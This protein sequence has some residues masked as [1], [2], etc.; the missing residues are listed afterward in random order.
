M[1]SS[2]SRAAASSSSP[3][4]TR[5]RSMPTPAPR[6][7]TD[8]TRSR[9][10]CR[11][12]TR[13]NP[14]G[15]SSQ[16][17]VRV[18]V[19]Y[20]AAAPHTGD[21]GALDLELKGPGG[22]VLKVTPGDA[23]QGRFDDDGEAIVDNS[24]VAMTGLRGTVVVIT[25]AMGQAS[26]KA[27]D[28]TLRLRGRTLRYDA[29]LVEPNEDDTVSLRGH[30]DPDTLVELPAT[31]H[32]VIAV[33]AQSS[34]LDWR[35]ADG[36]LV[37]INREVGRTAPFS[38]GG[39][40]RDGRFVPDVLAPGEFVLS[41]LSAAAP[42]T[43][44]RSAFHT[45]DPGLLLADDGVH[46]ALRGT[47]QA[48][49][50]VA[51]GVALL[52]ELAP[53]LTPTRMRELL[54][55]TTADDRAG[56]YGPRHGFGS[57]SLTTA[58]VKLRGDPAVM[59]SA[60][61]SDVGLNRDVA[62]PEFDQVTVT[63]TP[64]DVRAVPL[65]PGVAVDI[66]AD[67]GEWVGPVVDNQ[68]GRYERILRTR[69]PRG[70]RI[71]VTARAAGIELARHPQVYLVSERSEIGT[72]YV[73]GACT[74]APAGS[75]P[76]TGA[77]GSLLVAAVL[78]L[79]RK[80]QRGRSPL[81]PQTVSRSSRGLTLVLTVGLTACSAPEPEPTEAGRAPLTAPAGMTS[82][83]QG[84]SRWRLLLARRRPPRAPLDRHPPG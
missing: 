65:G 66:T 61:E 57:I 42:P 21:A 48:A 3:P 17:S 7:S 20:D 1:K 39:P 34:R 79:L 45:T 50:H 84:A 23:L 40:T 26:I 54:R 22:K 53:D 71:T 46:A 31:A 83:R 30:L 74:A 9:S 13:K 56:G 18:E 70:T 27:G 44:A 6:S 10:T 69:A 38:S 29:W 59:V 24:D 68:L 72:P 33:G 81:L 12:A 8:C 51:G 78:L 16:T 64:R 19:Y 35:R 4:A 43:S 47:S 62:T 14:T 41:A 67:A 36:Q 2:A 5:V 11:P 75:R 77:G 52:L 73:L 58:L 76:A 28:W 80:R 82:A 25:P 60:Y 55:T 32:S 49:P 15:P 37:L 63:V